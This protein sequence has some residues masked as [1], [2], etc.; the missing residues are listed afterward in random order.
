MEMVQSIRRIKSVVEILR[1]TLQERQKT[2]PDTQ[3]QMGFQFTLSLGD[4]SDSETLSYLDKLLQALSKFG[5][6]DIGKLALDVIP[7]NKAHDEILADVKSKTDKMQSL[8]IASAT[9]NLQA[10]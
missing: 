2:N 7:V 5:N 6:D 8:E 3:Y 9:P 10:R 1:D 4:K